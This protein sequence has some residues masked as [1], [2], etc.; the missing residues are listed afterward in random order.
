MT[1]TAVVPGS[2]AAKP[3]QVLDAARELFLRDG[4]SATSMDAIAK[5]AGVSKATVYAHYASKEDL[6]AAMM[7]VECSRTWPE[8]SGF[9]M[10]Q[11]DP[12]AKLREVAH[13][14]VTFITSPYVVGL[15]RVVASEAPRTPEIGRIF[16]ESGPGLGRKRFAELLALA[17]SRGLLRIRDPLRAADHFFSLLRGDMHIRR[18]IGLPAPADDQLAADADEVIA[19]F[20]RLYARDPAS[21]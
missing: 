1:D 16:Y 4:Y 20:L 18:L 13:R 17:D 3:R 2:R 7:R 6:F 9:E 11:L 12:I 5:A 8:L 15:L 19:M 21:A 10:S 14:Y